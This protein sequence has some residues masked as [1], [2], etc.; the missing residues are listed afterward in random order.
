MSE[1]K[2][3]QGQPIAKAGKPLSEAKAAM[4][5]VHGRGAAVE[6]ILPLV[7][8]FEAEGFAYLA[9]AAKDGTWYPNRFL[10]PRKSNEPFLPSALDTINAILKQVQEAGIPPEKTVLLGFSQGACLALEVAARNAQAYGAVVALSGGLIGA[11]DELNGYVGSFK[12]SP[13]FMGCSDIDAHIPVERIHK[14]AE[15]LQ[16]LG[17]K[18]DARIYKGMGHTINQDE[19]DAVNALMQKLV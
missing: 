4:I 9:P 13:I 17:A 5:M 11:D 15:I 14:S 16:G 2:I 8:H 6:S 19:I 3:H 18:V 12:G 1:A 10:A 7:N